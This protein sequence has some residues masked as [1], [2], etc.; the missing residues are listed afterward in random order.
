M[1]EKAQTFPV[2]SFNSDQDETE[3]DERQDASPVQPGVSPSLLAEIQAVLLP[4]GTIAASVVS[5]ALYFDPFLGAPAP[6]TFCVSLGILAAII[7]SLVASQFNLHSISAIVSGKTRARDIF[8][9]VSLGFLLLLCLF[10]LLKTTGEISRGWIACWYTLTLGLL[11]AERFGILLWAR[12]L[13]AENRL[14]QRAALYGTPDLIERVLSTLFVKDRNLVLAGTF[15]ESTD[16]SWGGA[17]Q[18]GL[19]DLVTCA[20]SGACDRII[21]ALPSADTA[22]LREVAARLEQLP[23]DVQLAPDAI[24][25]PNAITSDAGGLVLLSVQRRPLSERGY[26]IKSAMDYALGSIALALFAPAMVLIAIAIKRE[27]KGPIFFIQKRHGYNQR[28]I[29]VVK[30]RT[31]TVTEDGPVVTQ[32]VRGDKRITKVGRFLRRTSLDELPQLF[33]VLRGELSLVGPR[34]HAVAHNVSYAQVLNNYAS[35][36][37]MKPGITGWAQINGC[38]GETRMPEDMRKRVDFDLYYIK[39]WSAWLDIQILLRT[40]IVPFYS[41][42]AY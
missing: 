41:P 31:M 28:V 24:T 2:E 11:F 38:R 7:M 33:N 5:A 29:R 17:A 35:R 37:K 13:R 34:P 6:L 8:A 42:N 12:L 40:L 36:H 23:I 16:L 4:L 15:S 3:A 27:S 30:F 25:L 39:H 26:L 32:A 20:R 14:Q 21:V 22:S 10:Y 9:T 1:F 19:N 18:G